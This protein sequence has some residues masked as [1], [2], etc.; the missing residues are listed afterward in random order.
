M[1]SAD[2]WNSPL[3]NKTPVFRVLSY[4]VYFFNET[5]EVMPQRILC[6][7]AGFSKLS[8]WQLI[9]NEKVNIVF[10]KC[11]AM[12]MFVLQK[13]CLCYLFFVSG[14][15]ML[16]IRLKIRKRLRWEST[17]Q[18]SEHNHVTV[19][20]QKLRKLSSTS[21]QNTLAYS[22]VYNWGNKCQ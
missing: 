5:L 3:I 13:K 20:C 2:S 12:I 19:K 15:K 18:L 9:L 17:K 7:G 8:R 10:W 16:S 1:W 21:N 4:F 6:G 14:M 22:I 11:S